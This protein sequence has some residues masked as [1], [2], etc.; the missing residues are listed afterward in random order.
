VKTLHNYIFRQVLATLLMTVVV[1]TF[2]L[3]LGNV[4][5]QILDLLVARQATIGLVAE[6][7]GLLIPWVWA[8][9]LPM[10][11]LTA[12]LLVFGRFSADHELTA[13]RA[14]GISLVSLVT[15]V[16]LLSLAMC[17]LSALVNMEIA[18]HCRVAYKRLLSQV[19]VDL[20]SAMLPEGRF[21]NDFDGY[22][23]YIG[24]NRGKGALENVVVFVFQDKTNRVGTIEARR[25]QVTVDAASQQLKLRLS[26]ARTILFSGDKVVTSLQE[27]LE[28][29]PVDLQ[30]RGKS[31]GKP[32]ISNMT[33]TQLRAELRD[34]E[35]KSRLSP[36]LRLSAE[37]MR[38]MLQQLRKVRDDATTRIRV[39]IHR[40]IAFSFACFGF[41]L[42]G[43]PLGIRVHR[44]E[45]NVGFFVALL[46]VAVY[47]GLLLLGLGLDQHPEFAPHLI[48]W[49]PNFLFQSVGAVLLWRAN[50]GI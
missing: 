34:V 24:K 25:G 2:V 40:Q 38:T 32:D 11:M 43:I 49:I 37:Q 3:L 22:I 14:S 1:F 10:G 26:D 35:R 39:Q 28:M 41:T 44:R 6:A 45:T 13:V 7:I 23:F 17:A 4:L 31:G 5:K 50:R 8:F 9:A 12:T 20:S 21:I 29:P 27:E 18:P 42:I 36:G 47:Y 48:I 19:K 46:L 16:L 33:F 15:P 30:S